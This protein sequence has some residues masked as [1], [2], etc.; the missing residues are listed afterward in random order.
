MILESYQ[1]HTD[2]KKGQ[3]KWISG[4]HIP[5]RLR[6]Q[7]HVMIS[8]VRYSS[9]NDCYSITSTITATVTIPSLLL[10]FL[11]SLRLRRTPDSLRSVLALFPYSSH[12]QHSFSHTISNLQTPPP[13]SPYFSP[14]HSSHLQPAPPQ[15]EVEKT[16]VAACSPSQP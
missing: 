5:W 9:R 1:K 6:M 8:M 14:T 11:H 10:L 3:M 2:W 12:H 4:A 13:L 16:Y 15:P 7:M